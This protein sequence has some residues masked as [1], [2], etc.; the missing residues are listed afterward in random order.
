[1]RLDIVP[2]VC[3]HDGPSARALDIVRVDRRNI[4]RV[5]GAEAQTYPRG[6]VCAQDRVLCPT[7]AP[8][9]GPTSSRLKYHP[10]RMVRRSW[11]NDSTCSRIELGTAKAGIRTFG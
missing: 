11:R 5:R 9:R 4:R 1:M 10:R 3:P 6:A 8:P 2:T 7:P